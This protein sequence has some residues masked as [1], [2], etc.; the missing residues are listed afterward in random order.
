MKTPSRQGFTLF[1]LIVVLA[2]LAILFG[3]LLPLIAKA[4]QAAEKAAAFNNLKQIALACH[5]YHDVNTSF[6]P[7][8]DAS[9]FSAA[10]YLL[11]YLEQNNFFKQIDFKKPLTDVVNVPARKT[12]IP[13][14]LSPRD[15]LPVPGGAFGPT[16]YLFKAGSQ[17][18]LAGNDGIFYQ[19]SKTKI[20][21]ITDGTSNTLLAGETLRGDGGSKAVTVERQYVLLGKDAIKNVQEETGVDDFKA[22][23]H[24]AGDRGASWMDG[25]FLQG[26]FTA[27][28]LPNDVQP[29]VSCGGLGGVSALRSLE[30]DVVVAMCDGSVRPVKTKKLTKD[31]WKALSTRNG[32][33]A[34]SVDF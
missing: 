27:I 13:V 19:D 3:M 24:I 15:P 17:P 5:N 16:N 30:E 1:Q 9:N 26:T 23:K 29:D 12:N 20:Q 11:P 18:A 33:E 32:G 4:R 31:M 28:L 21:D 2:L 6:P 8:N 34:V 22:N 25:R 10:A 14:F 7:G